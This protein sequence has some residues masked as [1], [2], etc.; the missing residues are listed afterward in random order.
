[1]RL[2]PER[3]IHHSGRGSQYCSLNCKVALHRLGMSTQGKDNFYDNAIVETL[4]KTLKSEL[5]WR[6]IFFT[7]ADAQRDTAR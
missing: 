2:P 4:F 7:R 3:P 1:M 5:V 6:T